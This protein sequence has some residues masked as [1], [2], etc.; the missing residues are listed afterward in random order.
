MSVCACTCGHTPVDILLLLMYLSFNFLDIS[1]H[2]RGRRSRSTDTR[3]TRHYNRHSSSIRVVARCPVHASDS[4]RALRSSALHSLVAFDRNL[5]INT[6]HCKSIP[7]IYN[8]SSSSTTTHVLHYHTTT[9]VLHYYTTTVDVIIL[10]AS[11]S[12]TMIL[13]YDNRILLYYY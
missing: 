6:W 8:N 7:G 5:Q 2:C 1:F 13:V 3:H 12:T 10:L 4:S 11:F 9:V